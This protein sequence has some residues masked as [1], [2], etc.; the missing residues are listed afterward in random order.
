MTSV[1]HGSFVLH[2][3]RKFRHTPGKGN[4]FPKMVKPYKQTVSLG[5]GA[6]WGGL[7]VLQ[8]LGLGIGRQKLAILVLWF[9]C[10][11]GVRALLGLILSN[12]WIGTV[13][14]VAI[15][16]VMFYVALLHTPL[17]KYRF[18]VN[19]ILKEWYKKKYLLYSVA[20][21][22]SI[23]LGLILLIEHGYSAYPGEI[24]SLREITTFQGAQDHVNESVKQLTLKG[25][26][27]FDAAAITAASVDKSLQGFY[28]KSASFVFAEHLEVMAFM[29]LARK[30]ATL[31]A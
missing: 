7:T 25:Y 1:E 6:W 24:V 27:V 22:S 29:L 30:S 14:A 12:L 8:L 2:C 28:L 9:A 3:D 5:C 23:V 11:V 16:F 26:S 15:T 13:G 17:R 4:P 18:A 21:S 20:I 31:F 19:D 10:L